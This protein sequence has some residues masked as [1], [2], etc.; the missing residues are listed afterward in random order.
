MSILDED[1]DWR[2]AITLKQIL[3]GIADLLDTPNQLDPAQEE[4]YVMYQYVASGELAEEKIVGAMLR[5][6]AEN[7]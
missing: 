1:K 4:A 5:M 3:V 6:V 7:R 2:P